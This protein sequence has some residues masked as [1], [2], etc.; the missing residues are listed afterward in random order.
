LFGHLAVEKNVALAANGPGARFPSFSGVLRWPSRPLNV[1]DD[2]IDSWKLGF[3]RQEAVAECS[4]GDQRVIEAVMA[5]ASY[6]RI[7]LFDEPSA[8]MS[9]EETRHMVEAISRIEAKTTVIVIEHDLDVVR[10]VAD[11]VVVL[12][13]GE[14][15]AD[16]RPEDIA[17]DPMVRKIYWFEDE[18]A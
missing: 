9:S 11:R 8:G 4:Y 13:T 7:L 3:R 1:A 5:L 16:G 18:Q 2:L 12:Q 15:V 6:P 14:V 10:Q 17:Q